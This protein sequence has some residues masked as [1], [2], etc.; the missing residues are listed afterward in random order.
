MINHGLSIMDFDNLKKKNF[1]FSVKDVHFMGF[2]W[3]IHHDFGSTNII[4]CTFCALSIIYEHSDNHSQQ[5]VGG[6]QSCSLI[7][8]PRCRYELIIER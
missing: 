8:V 5:K 4:S 6:V 1:F 3:V 7:M 2:S